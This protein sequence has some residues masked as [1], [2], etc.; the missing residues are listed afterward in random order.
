MP[1]F[2]GGMSHNTSHEA[3]QASFAAY[4]TRHHLRK[5]PE[6]HAILDTVLGLKGH[7][8]AIALHDL[9][10][11][12]NYPVSLGTV[13]NTLRLLEECGMV[14]CHNFG[15][16]VPLYEATPT[17]AAASHHHLVCSVC[18]RV[19]EISNPDI[20]R[21]IERMRYDAFQADHFD[22]QIVG[23]CSRCMRKKKKAARRREST[24]G[25]DTRGKEKT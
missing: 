20:S 12:G 9:L 13:Y 15:K 1:N 17:N 6:R 5:T 21:A 19:R 4:M 16:R 14:K 23:V 24:D 25:T 22:L 18:G 11:C 3:A 8:S 10:E 7:F 2:V